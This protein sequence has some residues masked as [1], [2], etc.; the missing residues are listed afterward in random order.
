MP[1]C[2][3]CCFQGV[4]HGQGMAGTLRLAPW[5]KAFIGLVW[6]Q[7]QGMCNPGGQLRR[8]YVQCGLA[9]LCTNVV[10]DRL[11]GLLYGGGAWS[12]VRTPGEAGA[13]AQT[14]VSGQV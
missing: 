14:M 5:L 13:C 1:S 6:V 8:R 2:I 12:L 4:Q 10:S 11:G 3:A 9:A 7:E